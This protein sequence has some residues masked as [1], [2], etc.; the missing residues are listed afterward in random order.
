M[1]EPRQLH[2]NTT[3]KSLAQHEELTNEFHHQCIKL[4]EKRD[5]LCIERAKTENELVEHAQAALDFM[6]QCDANSAGTFQLVARITDYEQEQLSSRINRSLRE[7]D[8][9]E[10]TIQ[11]Y[12][13]KQLRALEDN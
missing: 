2:P 13:R 3:T 6:K 7:I 5:E 1:P 11:N 9:E 12:Y 10:E 4:D 8:D